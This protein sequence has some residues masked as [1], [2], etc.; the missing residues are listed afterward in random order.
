M[1]RQREKRTQSNRIVDAAK[2]VLR[3]KP[4]KGNPAKRDFKQPKFA[5]PV[6]KKNS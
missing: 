1:L 6:N 5:T 4:G 2:A 3:G